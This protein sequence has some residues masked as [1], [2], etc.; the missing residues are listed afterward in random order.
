MLRRHKFVAIMLSVVLCGCQS[1]VNAADVKGGN[2]EKESM[3]KCTIKTVYPD[4]TEYVSVD[5]GNNWFVDGNIGEKPIV[6]IMADDNNEYKLDSLIT[7]KGVNTSSDYM[8]FNSEISLYYNNDE[9]WIYDP[10]KWAQIQM[11]DSIWPDSKKIVNKFYL[12][13]D[14]TLETMAGEYRYEKTFK[15]DEN[16]IYVCSL[17]FFVT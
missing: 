13:T 16:N 10:Y 9:E 4:G 8:D 6:F 12:N 1:T 2:S 11:P 3:K 5:N 17:V 14:N 15:D 7:V